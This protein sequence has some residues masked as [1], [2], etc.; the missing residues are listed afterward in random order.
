MVKNG[1]LPSYILSYINI[2]KIDQCNSFQGNNSW[3]FFL[4]KYVQGGKG[5][6]K[7]TLSKAP[8]RETRPDHYTGNSVPYSLLFNCPCWLYNTEDVG[9]GAYDLLSLSEKTR[10]SNHFQMSLQR[11]HVLHSYFKTLSVGPVWGSNPRPPPSSPTLYQLS[12]PIGG[13]WIL[14]NKKWS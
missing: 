8:T 7:L 14:R 2:F 11:Q 4:A 6:M 1:L 12:W 3:S 5:A 10:T 9:D 13:K